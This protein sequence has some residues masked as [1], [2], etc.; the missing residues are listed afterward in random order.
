MPTINLILNQYLQTINSAFG[1]IQGHVVWLL[2]FLIIMNIVLSAML[3]ALSEDQVMVKLARK[4]VYI[5]F[6]V[7]LV[8]NWQSLCDTI[9]QS[10]MYLGFEAGGIG[11]PQ[12]YLLN[13]GNIAYRGFTASSPI[14]TEIGN[15]CGPIGFFK[16]FPQIALLTL[17][18][19]AI[20]AAFFIVAIQ[21]VVTILS[22]KLG[23]LAAFV[24]IPFGV[25][26]KTAFI[27]ER[28]LGWVVSSGVRLMVLTLVAGI[29]DL[30]FGHLQLNPDSITIRSALDIALGAIVLMVL[31]ITATRLAGDLV[32]GGPS[33]G[34]ASMVG[35]AG[36]AGAV[37][38]GSGQAVYGGGTF[39]AGS[40]VGASL[41]SVRA[42]SA[43]SSSGNMA[44]AA[45]GGSLPTGSTKAGTSSQT[46]SSRSASGT[47]PT[48][49]G[50]DH[51]R[52]GSQKISNGIGKIGGS[53][54]GGGGFSA[55]RSGI[56]EE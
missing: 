3:W 5:G 6:F 8:Q 16:N 43:I 9:A 45:G 19:L 27:A 14:M 35:A 44:M 25:L 11:F 50:S 4:I 20:L 34:A 46:T 47:S 51:L 55:G 23:S 40:M 10:F 26:S 48:S 33:L 36:G 13:P 1:L 29:G 52:S 24:L 31:A 49:L 22:F 30:A 38:F 28:P 15:L 56:S 17:A 54:G 7:W 53:G 37:A 18:V 39:L 41:A 21:A 32:S 42:A 12:V 2:N